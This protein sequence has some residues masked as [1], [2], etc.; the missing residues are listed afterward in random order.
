MYQTSVPVPP[1]AIRVSASAIRRW[2]LRNGLPS[3]SK[4]TRSPSAVAAPLGANAVQSLVPRG[5]R[6]MLPA[7]PG[8]SH[9]SP[10]LS[11]PA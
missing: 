1:L 7:S 6:T 11:S 10:A 5:R 2:Q 8:W 3:A 9:Q 4:A